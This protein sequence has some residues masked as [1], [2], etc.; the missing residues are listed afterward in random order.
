MRG[1]SIRSRALEFPPEVRAAMYERDEGLCVICG[2]L[3][4]PNAHFIPRSQG[5]LGIE[6][7][8]VTLCP[9]C[10][11]GYDHS[12]AREYYEALIRQYLDSFYPDFPDEDRIYHKYPKEMRV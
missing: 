9:D 1:R 2:K 6:E 5:G 10:H 11:H 4:I 3:G 8:G 12:G 7:N